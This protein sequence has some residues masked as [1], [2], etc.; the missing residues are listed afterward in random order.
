MPSTFQALAVALLALLLGALYAFDVIGLAVGVVHDVYREQ[1]IGA[2]RGMGVRLNSV[3]VAAEPGTGSMAGQVVLT[4]WSSGFRAWPGMEK[5]MEWVSGE[6]GTIRIIG[7]CALSLAH[8]GL[9]RAA[10]TILPGKYNSWDVAAGVIIAT[11]GGCQLFDTFGPAG[12]L[13]EHGLLVA[14]TDVADAVWD[15]WS[16]S[17]S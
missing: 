5:F 9:G 13:P 16:R 8:A 1:T 15:A 11:E 10:A 4:E 2:A 17:R 3:P 14:T 7:S 12:D 6:H